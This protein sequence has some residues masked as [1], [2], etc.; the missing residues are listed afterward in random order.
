MLKRRSAETPAVNGIPKSPF[1]NDVPMPALKAH[2]LAEPP[3]LVTGSTL[4]ESEP[5]SVLEFVAVGSV[6]VAR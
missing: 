3:A 4:S 6:V 1:G 5:N 2:F